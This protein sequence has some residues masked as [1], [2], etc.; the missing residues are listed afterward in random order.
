MEILKER[1]RKEGIIKNQEQLLIDGFLDCQFDIEL[2]NELG[3]EFKRRFADLEVTKILTIES[4][5]IALSCITAQYFH[6]PVVYARKTRVFSEDEEVY[7]AEYLSAKTK[8]MQNIMVPKKLIDEHDK[9]LLIDD[10]L[11]TGC[12]L[13]A[14]YE[15]V[16][17][18]GALVSGAGVAIEKAFYSGGEVL[19]EIGTRLES[20]VIIESM[21]AEDG[22]FV[23]R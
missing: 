22:T 5:G 19:R 16:V 8:T 10:V 23:F 12:A 1:L 2:F 3:K 15:I 13:A 17:N 20:L 11:E 7:I 9:V 18:A 21:D 14:L 4:S 6:V